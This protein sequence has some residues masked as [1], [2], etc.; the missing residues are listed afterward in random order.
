MKGFYSY[1]PTLLKVIEKHELRKIVEF[2]TGVS[3]EILAANTKAKITTYEES[4]LWWVFNKLKLNTFKNVT[5]IK[6]KIK[7]VRRELD[8]TNDLIIV[9]G[10]DRKAIVEACIHSMQPL[11]LIHDWKELVPRLDNYVRGVM[12]ERYHREVESN[13]CLLTNKRAGVCYE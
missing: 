2:G 9:D 6:K 12:R 10:H 1:L 4:R 5:L 8:D 11:I 7:T 13:T 3:T